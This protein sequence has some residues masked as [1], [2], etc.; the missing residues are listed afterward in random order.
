MVR[1]VT[2]LFIFIFLL[3]PGFLYSQSDHLQLLPV[4]LPGHFP[5]AGIRMAIQDK[6]GLLWYFTNNGLYRYDGSELLY[7][8]LNTDPALPYAPLYHFQPDGKGN[9]WIAFNKGA[10]RFNLKNWTITTL[11]ADDW[12]PFQPLDKNFTAM[13]C[14]SGG[15]TYFATRSG[16]IYLV[17]KNRLK[18]IAEVAATVT[19][20]SESLPGELWLASDHGL[21]NISVRKGHYSAPHFYELHDPKGTPIG[22]G[23]ICYDSIGRFLITANHAI[24]Q[25]DIRNFYTSRNKVATKSNSIVLN[26]LVRPVPLPDSLIDFVHCP[27]N[28]GN[29]YI[30]LVS[31]SAGQ[32]NR[33]YTFDFTT[34]TWRLVTPSSAVN[35]PGTIAYISPYP[36]G[37]FIASSEGLT[38]I[39][40]QKLPLDLF[41]N[42]F[43]N[44]NSIRAIY[45][46]GSTLF[47]G[48]YRDGLVQYNER[49][50]ESKYLNPNMIV[51]SILPWNDDS[52]ILADEGHG[53]YWYTVHAK[54]WSPLPI[55]SQ[56]SKPV[57]KMATVLCRVNDSLVLEG[58]YQ[59]VALIDP[60]KKR[61]YH[62]SKGP[63]SRVMQNLK[64]NAIL[65][66][67]GR[68]T[69]H[70]LGQYLIA[71]NSGT[72]IFNLDNGEVRYFLKP[73]RNRETSIF[74]LL[75]M[76]GETWMGSGGFGV[77]AAD[78]SGT[79]LP[80][81]WLNSRL[82]G[83]MIYSL[84]RCDNTVLIG[85]DQGFNILH[86]KDS[87]LT[88]YTTYDGLPANEFNQAAVYNDGKQ[89]YLGTVNGIIRWRANDRKKKNRQPD[90]QINNLTIVDANNNKTENHSFPY[91]P[92]DSQRIIIPAHVRY[93]SIAFGRPTEKHKLL[94]YAYRLNKEDDWIDL[95]RK[96]AITFIKTNPGRYGLEFAV[97]VPGGKWL[98]DPFTIPLIIEPAFQQTIYFKLLLALIFTGIVFLIFHY[99]EKQR[100]K[101]RDMRMK[102]AGDLH[103][104]VGSSLVAI[105]HLN[106]R[107]IQSA[108]LSMEEVSKPLKA[109]GEISEKALSAMSDI[110]WSIDARFDRSDAFVM[111][112]KDYVYHL[113]NDMDIRANLEITGHYVDLKMQQAVRQNLFLI[114]KE[115]MNNAIKYGDDSP[116]NVGLHFEGKFRLK[117]ANQYNTHLSKE[118]TT[119]QGGH[120]LANM[121]RRA[122]QIHAKLEITQKDN[123]FTL[124][125]VL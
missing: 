28:I 119:I 2:K 60:L 108:S 46:E 79:P 112:M 78:S 67:E 18:K 40:A 76:S 124:W 36:D 65:P 77:L 10:A 114:F 27:F 104:E 47:I 81:D 25:G 17:V 38:R 43:D 91:L 122:K 4:R 116:I 100:N 62:V 58:T 29:K 37:A 7:F 50:R 117:I 57:Q 9:I 11:T 125:V 118:N 13:A 86:L 20:I 74:S 107:A 52:L 31:G 121:Q 1:T 70:S 75:P 89:V 87:T 34:S 24:F 123:I 82:T 99:R 105:R 71:T 64:I 93:F 73:K 55:K 45:K 72:F 103:D 14:L 90:V 101:E 68:T 66:M 56:I 95:G 44:K 111:R 35:F 92:P 54:K 69:T 98:P 53:L 42:G 15:S 49:T 26:G 39:S 96:R 23:N 97:K 8:S 115:A 6:A 22:P 61:S 110:V 16:K 30:G 80:M 88:C 3:I 94:S 102:I 85:T 21:I 41:L 5:G 51:Y 48:S 106:N 84:T 19:K 83:Q 120:G 109:I 59:G 12:R 33:V 113:Q 32:S 63:L